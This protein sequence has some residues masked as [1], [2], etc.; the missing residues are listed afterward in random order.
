MAQT[1]I[2]GCMIDHGHIP[3]GPCHWLLDW[4]RQALD[5]LNLRRWLCCRCHHSP[6]DTKGGDCNCP[7]LAADHAA[8][9]IIFGRIQ[10]CVSVSVLVRQWGVKNP[11]VCWGW[12]LQMICVHVFFKLPHQ[13]LLVYRLIWTVRSLNP[14]MYVSVAT[15]VEAL[16]LIQPVWSS[17]T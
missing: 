16:V 10:N 17:G 13:F 9:T 12:W 7:R 3:L 1:Y 11:I 5:L 15:G 6:Q 8:I 14:H 2:D 4:P